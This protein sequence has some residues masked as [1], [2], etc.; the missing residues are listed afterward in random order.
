MRVGVDGGIQEDGT[1]QFPKIVRGLFLLS[2][3][4]ISSLPAFAQLDTATVVGTVA[5]SQKGVLPGVTVTARNV[6]TG[7][8]RTGVSGDDGGYRLAALPPG[9]YEFKAELSGFSVVTR[10]GVTLTAGSET[11][12]NLQ[13]A[14]SNVQENITVTAEAPVVSTTT[15]GIGTSINRL[16]IDLTPLI[17]RDYTSM[18]RLVPGAAANNSSYSFAG[19]RGRSNQWHV[20]GFDNS[21]DISGYQR[22]SPA[23]DAIAEVQVMVNGFKA[24]YGEASGGVVNVITRAGTNA[25]HGSGFYLFRNQD[26]M[27]K[28]PYATDVDPFQRVHYGGTL[29]GP[30]ARDRMQ[31]FV[32]YEREDRDTFSASTRTLPSRNANFAASTLQF[33]QTNGIALSYFPDI[34]ANQTLTIR[35]TRPEFV[36]VHK[37][38]VRL[39]NQLNA[40]HSFTYRYN[41]LSDNEPSGTSGSI[42]DFN[43]GTGYTRDHFGAMTHKWLPTASAVNEAYIQFGQDHNENFPAFPDLRNLSISGGFTLGGGNFNPLQNYVTQLVDNFT[44]VL[45][46]TRTGQHAIKSGAQVKFFRSD[47][48]FDSNF[49]G[50][51]TFPDVASFVAGTPTQFTQNQGDSRLK[52]PNDIYAF[53]LQDDW[54][55]TASLTFNAGLRYDYESAQTEALRAVNANGEPGPGISKDRNNFAPRFGFSWAPGATTKQSFYGGTGI[56]YDQV[57][58]NVI[59]NARFTPPKVIGIRI[60]NPSWPD[61][62]AGGSQTIPPTSLSIIDPDLVTPRNWNSQFGYRRELMTDLGLDV[63]VVYNRGSDQ[64]GIINTNAGI[65]GSASI[66]GGNPVRPDPNFTTKSFYT[67]LG[68]I[69]YK[70][71]LIDLKKRFS[72]RFQANLAY[73]LSKTTNNAF[74]FVSSVQVPSHPEL[75]EGPDDSDRRHRIEGH[76]EATMPWGIEVAAIAEYRSE[77]PLDITANS[78][79][80]NGDGITGDWVNETICLKIDCAGFHYTRNGVREVSTDEANRLRALFGLGPIARFEN[81]P[82]YFNVDLTVQRRFRIRGDQAVTVR[83]EAFNLLNLP[84]RLAP[85]TTIRSDTFGQYTAVDQPRAIQFTARYQF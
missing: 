78:R 58:L 19:S 20:D 45:P 39:D 8:T 52:R 46:S 31:Y 60:D 36:D 35:Q 14:P 34:P 80:L 27:S 12:I 84:Q 13:L 75:S 69:R 70:G 7:F 56:Y 73:T 47:S 61:P 33:L 66:T 59:G 22:Q 81:N 44:W 48:F 82:K 28:S 18:L 51:Y 32:T 30:I 2:L 29:G 40:R 79:D 85:G 6:A 25:L 65:P 83:A 23:V 11:V 37:F 74:N 10:Q 3:L 62:F 64:I 57:I 72:R 4:P 49:R 26:L 55:P 67:N 53:Y 50:T 68:H 63:S 77:G 76:V 71:L 43:G 15:S 5:D 38:S 42:Y 54:R 41:F 1:M 21:E 17:G 16:Q 24:E 9:A